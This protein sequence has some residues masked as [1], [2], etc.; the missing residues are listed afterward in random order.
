[1]QVI[2]SGCG[3]KVAVMSLEGQ[4]RGEQ[5]MRLKEMGLREGQEPFDLER[6]PLMRVKLVKLGTVEHVLFLTM[7]HIVSDGWSMA[8]L[9]REMSRLYEAFL[10]GEASPLK[11]LPVQ[12]ADYAVWQRE[13]LQ[14]EVLAEQI[15][16]WRKQLEGSWRLWSCQRI[17][18]GRRC[19]GR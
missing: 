5:E 4:E 10:K 13:W 15:G 1:M 12:Y 17:G 18:R 19:R 16:Y 9:V 6:G 2:H 7:H 11:A 14:G 8:V 3:V